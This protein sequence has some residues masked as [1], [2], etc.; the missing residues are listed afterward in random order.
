MKRIAVIAALGLAACQPVTTSDVPRGKPFDIEGVRAVGTAKI[1]LRHKD[2]SPI[3]SAD[4][5]W[6]RA[7]AA[8][9]ACTNGETAIPDTLTRDGDAVIVQVFCTELRS[10]GEEIDV[11]GLRA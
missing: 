3:T 4:E 1:T 8:Q 6:A 7:R 2:G 10:T 9:V 5:P 11:S